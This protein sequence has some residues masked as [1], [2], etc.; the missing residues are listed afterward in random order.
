M[1][2]DAANTAA[3]GIRTGRGPENLGHV[4]APRPL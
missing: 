2:S 4:P 1:T 3:R